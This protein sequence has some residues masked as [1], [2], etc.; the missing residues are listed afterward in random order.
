MS[1]FGSKART[2]EPLERE[3]A[4][5]NTTI[6]VLRRELETRENAVRRLE[7]LAR[8]RS[9]RID[10]LTRTIHQL[11]EQNRRLDEE[12]DRLVE[13]VRARALRKMTWP[14]P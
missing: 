13:M 3:N 6:I 4:E 8:A 12:A 14:K 11:R 7:I 10:N 2:P 1:A 5:L 9:T